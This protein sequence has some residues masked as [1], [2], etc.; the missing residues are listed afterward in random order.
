MNKFDILFHT[1]LLRISSAT[2]MPNI[3]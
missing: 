1:V 2:F 3:I